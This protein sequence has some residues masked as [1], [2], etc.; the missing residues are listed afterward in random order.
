MNSQYADQKELVD[1][2][3]SKTNQ[4]LSENQIKEAN[5]KKILADKIAKQKAFE[6]EIKEFEDRIRLEID[7]SALPKTGSGVLKWPLA[8]VKITQ[9]FGNTAFA[10]ANPVLYNGG[11]HN[12][13]DLRA[14]VG[15]RVLS[16]KGRHC[17]RSGRY[18]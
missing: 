3:K 5:F 13:I 4:V 17:G 14:T 1:M 8:F 16:A 11:G 7:P 12:A 6:D 2:N 9:Y 10:T 18:G 15:T